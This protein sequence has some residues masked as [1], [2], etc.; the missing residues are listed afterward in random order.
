MNSCFYAVG[1]SVSFSD[2]EIECNARDSC[3][4]DDERSNRNNMIVRD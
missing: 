1:I 2:D 3:Y 4:I